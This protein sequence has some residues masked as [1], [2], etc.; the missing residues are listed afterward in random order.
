MN[1]EFPKFR[2]IPKRKAPTQTFIHYFL[3]VITFGGM[4]RYLSD[5][6]TTIG[7]RIYVT[8]DWDDL[9]FGSRYVTM[10]HEREHLRQFRKYTFVGMS[11]LYLLVPLPF[12]FA[13]FRAKFEK[14]G[15]E[16]G[17]RAAADVWGVEHVRTPYYRKYVISQFTS[18]SYGW[19]WPFRQSLEKWYDNI[20]ESLETS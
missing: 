14:E 9:S 17:I 12:G 10:C 18:A 7:Y 1:S 4:R 5:Y 16:A 20:L 15:Y 19:M 3:A 6:Q 2:V 13:W 8:D 11:L